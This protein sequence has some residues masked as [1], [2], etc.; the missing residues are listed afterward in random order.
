M[1]LS[2]IS[3]V[4]SGCPAIGHPPPAAKHSIWS[5]LIS[6]A[7]PGSPGMGIILGE[8]RAADLV[9]VTRQM[10]LENVWNG[11]IDAETNVVDVYISYLR[12]KIDRNY[13]PPRGI[14]IKL[15]D[16]P[17]VQMEGDRLLMRRALFNIL[18]NAIKYSKDHGDVQF[19]AMAQENGVRLKISNRGIGISSDDLPYIFDRLFRADRA[20]KREGGGIGLGLSI[21]KWIIEAHQGTI[22]VTSNLNQGTTVEIELPSKM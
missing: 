10:I 22:H 6:N 4:Q 18:D 14:Q 16:V 1:L 15:L 8:L 13:M 5:D 20:R 19:S 7:Q 11:G 17:D 12:N 3:T 9:V 2:L 21:A